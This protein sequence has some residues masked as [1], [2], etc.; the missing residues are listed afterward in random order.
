MAR[1]RAA[2]LM[3]T[4]AEV[5]GRITMDLVAAFTHSPLCTLWFPSHPSWSAF[6]QQYCKAQSALSLRASLVGKDLVRP[7][8]L[9]F[10]LLFEGKRVCWCHRE[11][12]WGGSEIFSRSTCSVNHQNTP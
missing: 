12:D 10:Q 9:M 3:P 5:H 11:A 6:D 4:P 8:R 7:V 2:F 1:H